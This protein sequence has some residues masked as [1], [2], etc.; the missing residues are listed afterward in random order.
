MRAQNR[1]DG[2]SERGLA[3]VNVA[4]GADVNVSLCA[5]EFLYFCH[6]F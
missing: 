2:R 5:I 6:M 3:V 1:Q 4:D